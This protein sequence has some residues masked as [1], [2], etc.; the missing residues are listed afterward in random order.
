M[1][2][3]V[4]IQIGS[5]MI[6]GWSSLSVTDGIENTCAVMIHMKPEVRGEDRIPHFRTDKRSWNEHKVSHW[7]RRRPKPRTTVLTR[8]SSNL[9]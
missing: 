4:I 5:K 1:F 8:A 7:P 3:G 2:S 6:V 9:T